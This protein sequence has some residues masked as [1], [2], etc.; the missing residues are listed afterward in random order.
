MKKQHVRL[1]DEDKMLLEELRSK[2][3]TT[4]KANNRALALIELNKG[5]SYKEVSKLVNKT[6]QTV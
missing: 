1:T 3:N 6:Q 5:K 4:S 2:G